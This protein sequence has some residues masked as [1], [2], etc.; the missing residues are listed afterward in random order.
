MSDEKKKTKGTWVRTIMS[1]QKTV[2][3]IML[4]GVLGW[5]NAERE[6]VERYL[7][8][9]W[10]VVRGD[11][12]W[13]SKSRPTQ[14]GTQVD[15][16]NKGSA[17]G[18]S[19]GG[20]ADGSASSGGWNAY[21][22]SN[23][24]FGRDAK[25]SG[26]AKPNTHNSQEQAG[27]SGGAEGRGTD[28]YTG[29]S[30]TVMKYNPPGDHDRRP[31]WPPG[32]T[33]PGSGRGPNEPRNEETA[34]TFDNRHEQEP[35]MDDHE[36]ITETAPEVAPENPPVIVNPL[37]QREVPESSARTYEAD[38]GVSHD[39]GTPL[40]AA[41]QESDQDDGGRPNWESLGDERQPDD[42]NYQDQP[43]PGDAN[44]E[45]ATLDPNQPEVP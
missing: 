4:V 32:S 40:P 15:R 26:P 7:G 31:N 23:E 2:Y 39:D 28:S 9:L 11:D 20:E 44:S 16:D 25:T 24:K 21:N 18:L 1:N 6:A 12:G 3:L 42:V 45:P 19:K 33:P 30:V 41:G 43:T 34:P 36:V 14:R 13:P 35:A 10:G 37:T 22:K 38:H 8:E 29:T 5:L 17:K 27:S